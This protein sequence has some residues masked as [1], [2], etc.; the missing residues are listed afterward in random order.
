MFLVPYMGKMTLFGLPN[1]SVS[2][3]HTHAGFP[4]DIQAK[5]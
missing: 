5:N 4:I 2:E 1:N 3:R